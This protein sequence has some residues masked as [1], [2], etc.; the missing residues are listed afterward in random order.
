MVFSKEDRKTGL[1]LLLYSTICFVI[2][3]GTCMSTV[4]L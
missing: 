2:G 3:F 4:R 1:K